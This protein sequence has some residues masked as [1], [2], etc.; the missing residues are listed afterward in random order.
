MAKPAVTFYI[1]H[2]SDDLRVQEEVENMRAQMGDSPDAEMNIS[3]FDGEATPVAEILN[4]AMSYPFLA[5]RRLVIVRNLLVWI[6]RKGAGETGK[7]A[8]QQLSEAL[9]RLPEWS[10]LVFVERDKLPDSHKIVKLAREQASG[11]EKAFTVPKDS[12][13]WITK[14]AL[15]AYN[16]QIEPRAAQALASVTSDDLRRADNELIKLV[17][18]VDGQRPI[19]EK[20]VELLTP[21][22][23]EAT[24][25]QLVD[26]IAE[27]RG[28]AALNFL[29][30]LLQEKDEDPFRVYG[31]IVRQFRLLLL[32]KEHLNRTGRMDGLQEALGASSDYVAKKAAQQSRRFSLQDLETLY[33]LLQ[34]YDWQ[35]KTG[36]IDPLLAIDLFIAQL[37]T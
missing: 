21:Y 18:Y 2:G 36:R 7:Q 34:D 6:T 10:R 27:G 5:E 33:R 22:V 14:R 24:A 4:A 15:E 17:C 3:E 1:F 19:S 25:F 28:R 9:P 12:S 32:A 13:G 30:R 31:M 26:A 11:Y 23:A 16:A 35:M 29:Y 20:D 8:L 37:S